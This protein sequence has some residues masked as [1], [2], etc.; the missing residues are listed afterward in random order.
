MCERKLERK[1]ERERKILEKRGV[2]EETIK[3]RDMMDINKRI[4]SWE[5]RER[6]RGEQQ[7]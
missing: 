2:R 3:E 4:I 5:E 7:N 6:E 1:R